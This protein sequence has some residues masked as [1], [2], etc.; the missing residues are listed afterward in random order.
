[1]TFVAPGF[2]VLAVGKRVEETGGGRVAQMMDHAVEFRLVVTENRDGG[3]GG[4]AEGALVGGTD[5]FAVEAERGPID[6]REE[7][8]DGPGVGI[9]PAFPSAAE[10]VGGTGIT[11]GEVAEVEIGLHAAEGFLGLRPVEE[12]L[13]GGA[14][15][16]FIAG[17]IPHA[18]LVVGG[19]H[20]RAPMGG[21]IDV[22]VAAD[23]F[24]R[25]ARRVVGFGSPVGG[26]FV[27]AGFPR[28]LAGHHFCFDRCKLRRGE[29]NTRVGEGFRL[30]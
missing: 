17:E 9:G 14:G 15:M 3:A 24:L 5:H 30:E 2:A 21:K 8:L 18:R 7:F 16:G 1:M 11:D 13:A 12:D 26:H 4:D 27:E 29:R 10:D 22:R 19:A 28:F 6:F 25:F 20:V 23:G